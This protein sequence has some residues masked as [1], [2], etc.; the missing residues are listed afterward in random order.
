M[1]QQGLVH[2]AA[3]SRDQRLVNV[4]LTSAGA[5]RFQQAQTIYEASIRRRFG[6][7]DQAIQHTLD[8]LARTMITFLIADLQAPLSST[9]DL[10]S[11]ATKV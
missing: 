2:C 4:S 11:H 9:D 6:N 5:T 1:E 8:T 10:K 3:D 7:L